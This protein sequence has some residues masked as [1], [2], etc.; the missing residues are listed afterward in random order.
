MQTFKPGDWIKNTKYVHIKPAQI[1]S[2][3]KSS[4][5]LNDFVL[6][7]NGTT[8][9]TSE[10]KLWQPQPGEWCW[11]WDN[12]YNIDLRKFHRYSEKENIYFADNGVVYVSYSFCEPFIGQL[13]TIL[14][15]QSKG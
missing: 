12:E 4:S 9:Y 6:K 7:C 14:Q 8:H 13:P 3:Y 1:Q 2:V 15:S 10:S 11:F 5:R